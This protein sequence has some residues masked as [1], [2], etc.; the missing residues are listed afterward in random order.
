M[1]TEGTNS[2]T[3]ET[4]IYFRK[5]GDGAP[6]G[7]QEALDESRSTLIRADDGMLPDDVA[8]KIMIRMKVS[9]HS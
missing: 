3:Y 7:L 9:H 8:H 6:I 1:G 4:V 5:K 2:D